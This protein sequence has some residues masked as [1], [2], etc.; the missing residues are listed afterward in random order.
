MC[1]MVKQNACKMHHCGAEA[2]NSQPNGGKKNCWK[3]QFHY[4]FGGI[5][6]HVGF[7]REDFWSFRRT[8]VWCWMYKW[9]S[10]FQDHERV[11]ISAVTLWSATEP[12]IDISKN[13][14]TKTVSWTILLF[15]SNLWSLCWPGHKAPE[16]VSVC[17]SVCNV[18]IFTRLV[19]W[20]DEVDTEP[21]RIWTIQQL[22]AYAA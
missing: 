18:F 2:G 1:C 3:T 16:V 14:M 22:H 7:M 19:S 4:S 21:Q 15:S 6:R 8:D 20:C 10:K 5:L 12:T 11:Q 17:H 9:E 13:D